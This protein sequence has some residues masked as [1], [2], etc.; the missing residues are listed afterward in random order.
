MRWFTLIFTFAAL[1]TGCASGSHPSGACLPGAGFD[2]GACRPYE[3]PTH[4]IPFRP[5]FRASVTQGFHGFESHAPDQPFS[6][7]FACK[8]GE[9][10]VA[11]AD[12]IVWEVKEDSDS[13]CNERSCLPQENYVILD[14]GDGTYSLYNHLL[15]RGAL[16]EVGDQVCQGDTVGLC[17]NTGYSFAPHL[18]YSV[19]DAAERTV[20]FRFE[21]LIEE[22]GS[23][24]PA[25]A[26][27]Y[28]STNSST[29]S[30]SETDYSPLGEG[31]F[32]HKGIVLDNPLPL[33]TVR[34]AKYVASG[35][36][37]G[38]QPKVSI[39]RKPVTGGSWLAEC[40]PLDEDGR[41]NVEIRWPAARFAK[42]GYFLMITG[43]TSECESPTWAWSY[44]VHVR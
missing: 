10:I 16:V 36:Y 24:I 9:P 33:V 31:A 2:D 15:H 22:G 11:T 27:T 29:D 32:A 1:L 26:S 3:S 25:P 30:C 17:G 8:E 40:F 6:V 39:H 14:H 23:G 41:F 44:K 19:R 18:H 5:G 20:P 35:Q 42:G 4:K 7:D 43:S 12:G 34:G 38:D 37:F 13:G 28:T 21:E